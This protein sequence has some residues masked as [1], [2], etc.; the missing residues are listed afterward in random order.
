MMKQ[1][2]DVLKWFDNMNNP[3]PTWYLEDFYIQTIDNV[4]YKLKAPFNMSFI[5]Q[6][7]RVFKVFD[8]QDSGNLCFG[9]QNGDNR[10]FIK[11]TGAPT[12]QYP[13]ML[14]DAVTRLKATV[15]VYQDL[16]H[17][18]LIKF[19]KAEEIGCGFAV[20]FDWTDGE[21]MGRMWGSSRFMSP[22]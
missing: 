17:P 20:V 22:E 16:A 18:N 6:Y 1:S 19:I 7:G 21:C 2:Q 13:R 14:E 5:S 10:Y 15:S 8:D 4:P 9:I 12:E 3:I 11:F